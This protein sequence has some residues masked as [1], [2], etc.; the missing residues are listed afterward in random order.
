MSECVIRTVRILREY[1]GDSNWNPTDRVGT[2]MEPGRMSAADGDRLWSLTISVR[3]YIKKKGVGL[4]YFEPYNLHQ[5]PHA[6]V[7]L[8]FV[9]RLRHCQ[10]T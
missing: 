6:F 7:T 1:V 10:N 2:R 3:V 8:S 9:S 4:I 5:L